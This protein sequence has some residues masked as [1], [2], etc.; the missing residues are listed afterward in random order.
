MGKSKHKQEK[1]ERLRQERR[2]TANKKK[3]KDARYV[4]VA[5]KTCGCC[6]AELHFHDEEAA[7]AA[8]HKAR[9]DVAAVITDD[10]GDKHTEIDTFY[11]Y[12]KPD[13]AARGL[14]YLADVVTGKGQ[15]P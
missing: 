7:K 12:R 9:L 6:E 8:F 13:E 15:W 14:S 10:A 11:G 2:K 4:V 5:K 1:A 3:Y